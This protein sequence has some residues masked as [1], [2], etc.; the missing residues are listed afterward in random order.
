ME[1]RS[2]GQTASQS[3]L[4]TTAPKSAT[5]LVLIHGQGSRIAH[6]PQAPIDGF[7]ATGFR[8]VIFDN[9]DV[10]LS[11]RCAAPGVPLNADEI[12]GRLR[13]RR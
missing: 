12:L 13:S 4:N 10:V 6:W 1:A 11:Q 7:A 5:P 2:F 8:T 9:R 3:R